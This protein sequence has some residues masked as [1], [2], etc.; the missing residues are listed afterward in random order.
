MLLETIKAL[1]TFAHG[2]VSHWHGKRFAAD[3]PPLAGQGSPVNP[4]FFHPVIDCGAAYTRNAYCLVDRNKIRFTFTKI[5]KMS[6]GQSL[7]G[8]EKA[9]PIFEICRVGT[10][11]VELCKMQLPLPH[12][13]RKR[14]V[15]Y[16]YFSLLILS[17]CGQS[18]CACMTAKSTM[19]RPIQFPYAEN[20]FIRK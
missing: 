13:T 6:H 2:H 7:G 16:T 20:S 8:T 18:N 1:S 19:S 17:A 5:A 15:K 14:P 11:E 10:D 12:R 9:C 3:N 4:M